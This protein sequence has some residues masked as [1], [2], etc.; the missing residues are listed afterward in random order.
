MSSSPLWAFQCPDAHEAVSAIIRRRSTNQADVRDVALAGL[1]LAGAKRVLDLGCGFGFMSQHIAQ[2][3]APDANLLGIDAWQANE[4]PFLTR[5][6]AAGRAGRFVC[7]Q[8]GGRL[9]CEDQSFDLVVCSYS[10]YFFAEALPEIARVL[11]PDGLFLAV[12]HSER[13][14]AGLLRAADVPE[15]GSALTALVRKFSAENGRALL[16][17]WFA[18]VERVDYPNGLMF[19]AEHLEDLLAYVWFKLPLLAPDRKPDD[20][21]PPILAESV[22]SALQ[23]AGRVVVEKDDTAFRCRKPLCP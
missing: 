21:L 16:E 4:E 17:P 15:N 23:N 20:G 13:S 1:D 7:T 11:A 3:V 19:D 6:S 14:F 12:T 22:R 10:L 8:I 18:D 9:P 2:R 5:V